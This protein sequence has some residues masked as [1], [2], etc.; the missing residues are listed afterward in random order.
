MLPVSLAAIERANVCVIMIDASEGVTEQDTKVA[1]Y[2]HNA[3]KACI[4]AVNKWDLI[5]KTT[6]T[7]ETQERLIRERFAFMS[8]APV[9]FI[10]AKTGQRV[11]KLFEM[12]SQVHEQSGKRLTTRC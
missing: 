3:G 7:L 10:S 9:I 11:D 5:E 4:I 12:I 6:G 1:G 2:A 8:Y